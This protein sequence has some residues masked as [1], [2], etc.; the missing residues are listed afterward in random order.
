[1]RD[2]VKLLQL[3][4]LKALGAPVFRSHSGSKL[5]ISRSVSINI[6]SGIVNILLFLRKS[7]NFHIQPN[8]EMCV[9]VFF[10]WFFFVLFQRYCALNLT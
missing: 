10:C 9:S 2:V 3:M 8:S 4:F 5:W 7:V 1:M 6:I